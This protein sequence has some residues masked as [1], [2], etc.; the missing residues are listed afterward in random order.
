M[1]VEIQLK[2]Q[3]H[4]RIQSVEMQQVQVVIA[5]PSQSQVTERILMQ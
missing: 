4:I 1:G 2:A 5:I 3:E